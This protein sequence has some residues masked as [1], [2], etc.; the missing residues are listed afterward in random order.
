MNIKGN[1][2]CGSVEFIVSDI[3]KNIYQCH[4][5]LCRKQGGSASNSGA[6]VPVENVTWIKGEDEITCWRKETGFSSNFCRHCGSPVPNRL[7][8]M[9]YYWIPVGTLEDAPFQIAANLYLDSKA[10]WGVVAPTG[11]RFETMP[12]VND[13]I[14]LLAENGHGEGA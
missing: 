10:S 8:G 7:R 11:E 1:C 14:A 2:L 4:C 5:T 6:I 9:D 3:T 13:F 12:E